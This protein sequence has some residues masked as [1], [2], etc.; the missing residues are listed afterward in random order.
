MEKNDVV[1]TSDDFCRLFDHKDNPKK[2]IIYMGL[3]AAALFALSWRLMKTKTSFTETITLTSRE[4][5]V[6][7]KSLQLLYG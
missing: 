5:A 2:T 7:K 1:E 4:H 6:F 3:S